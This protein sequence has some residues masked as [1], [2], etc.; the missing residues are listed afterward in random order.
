MQLPPNPNHNSYSARYSSESQTTSASGRPITGVEKILRGTAITVAVLLVG[1]VAAFSIPYYRLSKRID[2]QIASGLWH[3]T[4]SYYAGAET[5]SPGDTM[6]P[7]DL[8]AALKRAGLDANWNAAAATIASNPPVRVQFAGAHIAAITDLTS[9]RRLEQYVVPPQ[10]VTNL[11][12]D[13]HAKLTIVHYS[14]LPPVLVHA[15]VSAEDKHFFDHSGFDGPRIAKAFYVDL[16]QHRKEQ[17][18]S[19]ITMQLVRNVW[20]ERDKSWK[21]KI[22]EALATLHLERKLTKEQILEDYCNTVYLGSSGTFGFHGFAQAARAYFNK[23]VHELSLTESAT[24]AG[25]IQRPTYFDPFRYPKRVIGRR[26]V[27]LGLMRDNRYVTPVEYQNALAAPLGVHPGNTDASQAQYFFDAAGE[28]ASK[29][30]GDALPAGLASIYTTVDLRLQRAAEQAIA[31]GMP[32]VDKQLAS[33]RRRG[34]PAPEVA[35]IALDTQTG[36][37]KALCGGRNY[38]RSQFD[39]VFAKRP[40]GSVF[41]PFVYAAAL[42]TAVAG[43]RTIW[44]P[45]STIDDSPATFQSG[46]QTYTP[47]N[48]K[49]EFMGQVSLRKALAHSLNVATVKL[50]EEVGLADV[51]TMA[52][53]AGLNRDIQATPAVALGAYQVTPFEIARAYTMF[54]DYGTRVQPV[55]FSSIVDGRGRELYRSQHQGA[56]ELDPRVAFLMV[57]MLQEVM[58]SGTA[59]GVRARGFVLPAAGKTGTSH[60]GWFAGFTSRLLCIV[61]VGYDDY[62]DLGLE[63][64]RSALPIWTEFMMQAARYGQYGNVKP[65]E[66][67]PGVVKV[68]VNPETGQLAGPYCDGVAAYFIQGT[69]PSKECTAQELEVSFT[70]DGVTERAVSPQPQFGGPPQPHLGADRQ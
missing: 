8:E 58:R 64:A 63:G 4:F 55:F 38:A 44:T 35:L 39:R 12:N 15:I 59:A 61:W 17:G 46:D 69:Q 10:L 57:D 45:S 33:V 31:D 66:P 70:N 9:G 67:P 16:R 50:A 18:A 68:S 56:R 34:G 43:G 29:A 42:N 13:G 26:N 11:I 6:A 25:M 27:V 37:V 23:D 53:R 21:R 3:N 20:L 40:P 7:A 48:F 47:S 62:R 14:D 41:K 52:R 60:D 32:L 65:F 19:T 28:E 30:L 54:A 1:A 51:V 49:G 24:L 22:E 5:L 36:E 2:Q